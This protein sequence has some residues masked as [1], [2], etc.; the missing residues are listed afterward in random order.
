M[1]CCSR[2]LL[3]QH[4]VPTVG[5]PYSCLLCHGHSPHVHPCYLDEFRQEERVVQV[6]HRGNCAVG[7]HSESFLSLWEIGDW[8]IFS[9]GTRAPPDNEKPSKTLN[10]FLVA[11]GG[12]HSRNWRMY[13]KMDM[14]LLS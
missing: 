2:R 11:V 10:V 6:L 14:K 4:K 3:L 9:S 13:L 5:T 7:G 1:H 12:P 8:E